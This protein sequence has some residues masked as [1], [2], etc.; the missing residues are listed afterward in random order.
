MMAWE[1]SIAKDGCHLKEVKGTPE[2]EAA[3]EK[4]MHTFVLC[5][6]K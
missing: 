5:V 3:L 2:E 6:M 1:T 4:V